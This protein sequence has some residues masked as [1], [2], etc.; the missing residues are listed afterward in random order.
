MSTGDLDTVD[1]HVARVLAAMHPLAPVE[2][3]LADAHGHV[4]AVDVRS[5]LDIPVFDNSAMDGYA[6]QHADVAAASTDRPVALRIVAE[7]AAGS[8]DDPLFGAGEAVRI[9]TGAP[10]PSSADAVV[11][12]EHTDAG[13]PV[14]TVSTSPRPGAHVR[15]AGEDLRAGDAVLSAGVRLTAARVS[16][17]AAAGLAHVAVRR[18]PRVGVISTGSELVAPGHPLERG[19]IPESNS[20]LLAGLVREACADIVHV[21]TVPDDEAALLAELAR[22]LDA[23]AE[24]IVLSGGVSVGAHDVVKATLAPLGTVGFHRIAMQPGKPQAFGMLHRGDDPPTPVF[25]LPG[26]PVSTAVSFEAFVRPALM[27]LQGALDVQRPRIAAIAAEGWRVPSA[28]VQFMPVVLLDADDLVDAGSRPLVRPA[29]RGGAGSHLVGGLAAADGYAIVPADVD[30][31]RG[32][33]PVTVM[34]VAS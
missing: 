27:R 16:A 13:H 1:A 5:R 10:M 4:L 26:N 32:G 14:V 20:L 7:V 24:V 28:R 23:G 21:A 11:P 33:D 12:V 29:T 31:V 30:E 8:A 25:G 2:L 3:P 6:V 15:R 22:G 34:L 17:L 9:M 19:Q 18:A